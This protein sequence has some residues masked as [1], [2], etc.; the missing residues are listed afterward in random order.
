MSLKKMKLQYE[1]MQE[2]GSVYIESAGVCINIVGAKGVNIY[3]E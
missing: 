2:K 3:W 1:C